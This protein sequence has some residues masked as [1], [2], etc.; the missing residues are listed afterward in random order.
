MSS[1][2]TGLEQALSSQ[3]AARQ[4]SI[5][6]RPLS[7]NYPAVVVA[8]VAAFVASALWYSPLLFGT[9]YA[10][11]RGADPGA[12]GP[13]GDC[14]RALRTLV[15][16]YVFARCVALFGARTR[17][18]APVQHLGVARVPHHDPPGLSRARERAP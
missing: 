4:S 16:A 18:R 10:T 1:T 15:I 12:M 17:P 11:M 14:R 7:I 3:V 9:L 8:A 6:I 2:V 13:R 5:G